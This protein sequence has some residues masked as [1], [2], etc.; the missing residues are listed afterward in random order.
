MTLIV[1]PK[2]GVIRMADYFAVWEANGIQMNEELMVLVRVDSAS[3]PVWMPVRL[4]S[5]VTVVQPGPLVVRRS[6]IEI[7]PLEMQDLYRHARHLSCERPSC[8]LNK[9]C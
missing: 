7:Q 4:R 8:A 1:K 2:D 3:M 5:W 6:N 9:S